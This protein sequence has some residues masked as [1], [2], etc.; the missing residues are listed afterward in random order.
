M[1]ESRTGIIIGVHGS[2]G[3][4]T[5]RSQVGADA[6]SN[7]LKDA[8]SLH[9]AVYEPQTRSPLYQK[10]HAPLEN[11][12]PRARDRTRSLVRS[13]PSFSPTNIFRASSKKKN[14]TLRRRRF[15][16]RKKEKTSVVV[17]FYIVSRGT[18]DIDGDRGRKEE[19]KKERDFARIKKKKSKTTF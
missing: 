8:F 19:R 4:Q 2:N 3:S 1:V 15:A 9:A 13:V 14:E 7:H 10:D 5:R 12:H 6:R 16:T 18:R 17:T 11:P